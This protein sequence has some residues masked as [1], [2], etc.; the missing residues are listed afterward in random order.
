MSKFRAG[1]ISNMHEIDPNGNYKRVINEIVLPI[2]EKHGIDKNYPVW[3][4]LGTDTP[5]FNEIYH[6]KNHLPGITQLEYMRAQDSQDPDDWGLIGSHDSDPA[7]KMIKKDWVRG[8]DA[9]NIFYLAGFLNSNPT[10]AKFRDEFCKKIDNDDRE[11]VK[12]KF[13]EL[14]LTCKKIQISFADF[15]GIDKTYNEGGKENNQ[16]WKL[17][18]NKDYEDSYYKN[19]ASE[20]PTALNMPEILK[21]AVQAKADFNVVNSAQKNN[22]PTEELSPNN[23]PEVDRILENLDKYQRILEEPEE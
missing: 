22:I 21:L 10:R 9:W 17:R 15:F 2:L 13:A 14:F 16:N 11:R 18:L 4:D 3:E 7:M 1:N 6:K 8:H 5:V 23:P 19:L 12:A 20:H